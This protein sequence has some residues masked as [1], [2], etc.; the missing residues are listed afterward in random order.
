MLASE[1]VRKIGR[2]AVRERDNYCS[3]GITIIFIF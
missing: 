1:R 2:K 3:V